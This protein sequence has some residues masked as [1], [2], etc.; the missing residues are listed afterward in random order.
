MIR[1]DLT[2]VD[3]VLVTIASSVAFMI[4]GT[5]RSKDLENQF[6]CSGTFPRVHMNLPSRDIQELAKKFMPRVVLVVLAK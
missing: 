3:E 1:Q 5:R 2:K 6:P 4:A